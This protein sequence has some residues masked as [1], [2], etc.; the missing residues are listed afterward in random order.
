MVTPIHSRFRS[1]HSIYKRFHFLFFFFS[2]RKCSNVCR[3]SPSG[4]VNNNKKQNS[5][6]DLASGGN[7]E[8]KQLR[9]NWKSNFNFIQPLIKCDDNTARY[10]CGDIT[11]HKKKMKNKKNV[12]TLPS[13]Q[14]G[15]GDS[16]S[17]FLRVIKYRKTMS[18][19]RGTT[20]RPKANW[21]RTCI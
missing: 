21:L 19:A 1:N 6:F 20:K 9:P 5:I 14:K 17:T 13:R 4:G 16:C 18:A 3:V 10:N 7:K 11:L 2:N 12:R 15:G 8:P